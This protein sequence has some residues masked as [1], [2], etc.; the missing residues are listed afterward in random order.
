MSGSAKHSV[1]FKMH[2]HSK[3]GM[4]L[5]KQIQIMFLGASHIG[6]KGARISVYSYLIP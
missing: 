1:S 2:N 5:E 6:K 3:V 4:V